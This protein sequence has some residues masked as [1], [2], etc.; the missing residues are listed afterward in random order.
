MSGGNSFFESRKFKMIMKYTYGF[1]AAIVIVGALFK[2][3]HWPGAD[4]MLIVGLLTDKAIASYANIPY[5][6]YERR[7]NKTLFT[8]WPCFL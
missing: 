4:I 3:L 5:L 2:I 6:N 7:R 8:I 1:G